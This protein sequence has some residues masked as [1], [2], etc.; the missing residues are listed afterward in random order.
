VVKAD[1][2]QG[3]AYHRRGLEVKGEQR[4]VNEE[5]RIKSEEVRRARRLE[6]EGKMSN[7][8]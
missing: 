3:N 2:P 6:A 8:K 4:M 7:D 5:F 1:P